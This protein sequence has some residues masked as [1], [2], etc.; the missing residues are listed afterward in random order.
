LNSSSKGFEGKRQAAAVAVVVA[1]N[2]SCVG[3]EKGHCFLLVRDG[4]NTP[5]LCVT[6]VS[7]VNGREGVAKMAAERTGVDKI[8]AYHGHQAGATAT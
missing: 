8:L 4:G 3:N 7:G 1:Y 6:H 2:A 5:Y